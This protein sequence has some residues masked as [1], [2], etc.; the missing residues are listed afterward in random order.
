VE[1]HQG[2][3]VTAETNTASERVPGAVGYPSAEAHISSL[4]TIIATLITGEDAAKDAEDTKDAAEDNSPSTPGRA[5][6]RD[7]RQSNPGR[8]SRHHQQPVP[9]ERRWSRQL[10]ETHRHR[11]H[12]ATETRRFLLG[13]HQDV[14]AE[15][16]GAT[17][18]RSPRSRGGNAVSR[19]A[20]TGPS[21]HNHTH[22]HYT[23]IVYTLHSYAVHRNTSH[24]VYIDNYTY[25]LHTNC[26]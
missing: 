3:A 9:P 13:H 19:L 18:L 20:S 8:R 6:F 21:H 25:T 4:E 24:T 12:R 2:P 17:Q 23:H 22:L 10:R 11:R 5:V 15:D 1:A 7:Q 26:T 16:R 14:A